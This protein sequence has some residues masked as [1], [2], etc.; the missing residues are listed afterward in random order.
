MS[1]RVEAAARSCANYDAFPL[2]LRQSGYEAG[3]ARGRGQGMVDGFATGF[4]QGAQVAQEVR[5]TS[6]Q[7]HTHVINVSAFGGILLFA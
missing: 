7:D 2:R 5:Y 6:Y 1:T 4:S 3:V